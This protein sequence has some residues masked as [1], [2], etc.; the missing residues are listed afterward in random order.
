[1]YVFGD[2]F[3]EKGVENV[4]YGYYT[5]ETRDNIP[6]GLYFNILIPESINVKNKI[7]QKNNLFCR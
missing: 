3:V 5:R 1:M 6:S 2:K 4:P 7:I